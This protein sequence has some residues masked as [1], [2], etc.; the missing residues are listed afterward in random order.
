[1]SILGGV[2][3]Y[4]RENEIPK[5]KGLA[6]D[7]IVGAVMVLFLLQILPESMTSVLAYLPSVGDTLKQV[8]GGAATWQQGVD[9][10]LQIGP[11]RF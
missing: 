8:G 10:D 3:E 4:V 5:V 6:R 1:M 9:P 7:F 2:A 11:A